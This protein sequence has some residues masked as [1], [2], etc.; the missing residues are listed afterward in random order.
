MMGSEKNHSIDN[1]ARHL[2]EWT[3]LLAQ[4]NMHDMGDDKY[5]LTNSLM[6]I[7]FWKR[8]Y[9][10]R[11][12]Y[13]DHKNEYEKI[14]EIIFF[15]ED[16]SKEIYNQ[17]PELMSK[18]HD[19][20]DLEFEILINYGNS[21]SL[22]KIVKNDLY[23]LILQKYPDAEELLEDAYEL[24]QRYEYVVSDLKFLTTDT[25]LKNHLLVKLIE[26]NE[27]SF[28]KNHEF[29]QSNKDSVRIDCIDTFPPIKAFPCMNSCRN[30][31]QLISIP[32]DQGK[33]D[34]LIICVENVKNYKSKTQIR[35]ALKEIEYVL[36]LK[37][38]EYLRSLK[39]SEYVLLLK[40][41]EY[42]HNERDQ[43]QKGKY[44]RGER[45]LELHQ[46][47][48]RGS[49]KSN[50]LANRALG[51]VV[52]DARK[53]HKKPWKTIFEEL[54]DIT[55]RKG[56]IE[57]SGNGKNQFEEKLKKKIYS[58]TNKCITDGVFLTLP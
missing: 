55:K 51:L 16:I 41:S 33:G 20:S 56:F 36:L 35:K 19:S 40:Q 13:I 52:W 32:K 45:L 7:A 54:N 26:M 23:E 49:M 38:S 46:L 15:L 24:S 50:G 31:T 42:A 9:A 53:I 43:N 25:N 44:I 37:Q 4:D 34:D 22:S 18:F 10:K 21:Q 6:N 1:D 11:R 29:R 47:L 39:Q 5:V 27:D 57:P 48:E 28:W 17:R 3:E 2:K 58:T 8:E 14:V 12:L 30:G